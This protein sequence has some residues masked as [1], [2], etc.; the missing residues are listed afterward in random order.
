MLITRLSTAKDIDASEV[1][2]KMPPGED[3]IPPDC[4]GIQREG[5]LL[6]V[7]QNQFAGCHT[8]QSGAQDRAG[9]A[10]REP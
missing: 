5:D 1:F 10:R 2:C 3:A 8:S 9:L 6:S 4:F 7:P